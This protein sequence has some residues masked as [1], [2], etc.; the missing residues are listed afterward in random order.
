MHE[1]NSIIIIS[2]YTTIIT[3]YYVLTDID[4]KMVDRESNNKIE[5]E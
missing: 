5:A 4:V 3:Y 2:L 1:L